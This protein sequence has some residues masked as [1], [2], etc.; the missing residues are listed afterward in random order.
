MPMFT[1]PTTL[2]SG[3]VCL[4]ASCQGLRRGMGKSANP[5]KE[6]NSGTD[7]VDVKKGNGSREGQANRKSKQ[8]RP[9]KLEKKKQ[10]QL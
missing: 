4:S 5:H 6:S 10:N 1:G 2:S 8:Q 9:L 3:R 7:I